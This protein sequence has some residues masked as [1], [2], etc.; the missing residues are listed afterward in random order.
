MEDL[1]SHFVG[2]TYP[3]GF[4]EIPTSELI[5]KSN[6]GQPG[7]WIFQITNSGQISQCP[8]GKMNPPFCEQ[9]KQL[10]NHIT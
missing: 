1:N 5:K 8:V 3:N 6:V 10:L 7:K 2:I 9:G 4:I